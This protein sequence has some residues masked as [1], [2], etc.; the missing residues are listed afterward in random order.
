MPKIYTRTGDDGT[1]HLIGGRTSKDA[2]QI[3]AIGAVDELN[4]ALGVVLAHEVGSS[5]RTVLARVQAELFTFG[6][7]LAV[8]SR[9]GREVPHLAHAHVTTLEQ[10][11]DAATVGLPP[12]KNF[13]LPGGSQSAAQLHTA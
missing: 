1:T 8:G 4:A 7:E 3:E 9:P 12:L 10:E 13:V 11:I 5:T 2:P 6:A